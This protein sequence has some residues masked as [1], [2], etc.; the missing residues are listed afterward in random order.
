MLKLKRLSL[1]ETNDI[2]D[3]ID[4]DRFHVADKEWEEVTVLEQQPLSWLII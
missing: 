4:S 1:K 3:L 2:G